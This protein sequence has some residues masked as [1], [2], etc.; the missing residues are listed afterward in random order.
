MKFIINESIPDDMVFI[1]PEY[2]SHTISC[3]EE[4]ENEEMKGYKIKSKTYLFFLIK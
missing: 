2:Y 4:Y 1:V 3:F